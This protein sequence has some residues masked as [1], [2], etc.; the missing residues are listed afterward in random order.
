VYPI[1]VEQALMTFP[2]VDDV[3]VFG[4]DDERWGQRVCAAIVS[5]RGIDAAEL[6]AHARTQLA[7]YKVPKDVYVVEE[8]PH[9]STGKVRRSAIAGILGV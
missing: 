4:I 3:A 1:E 9:T 5:T 7:P 6:L 2:G 8:L